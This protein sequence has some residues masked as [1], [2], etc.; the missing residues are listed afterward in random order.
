LK[1]LNLPTKVVAIT[2]AS[3]GLGAGLARVA[4]GAGA[5]VAVC[6]RAPAELRDGD[7]VLTA[8]L[9]VTDH[10]AVDGFA[11]SAFERFG[12]V[13]LWINNA[14]VIEPIGPLRSLEPDAVA[15]MLDVNIRGVANGCR[16]YLR[17]LHERRSRGMLVNISSGAARKAFFGWSIYCATKAAVDRM[18]EGIALE[19]EDTLDA[20]WSVAP[21]VIDTDMQAAI[22]SKIEAEF[23]DVERF[24]QMLDVGTLKSPDQTAARILQ[25]ALDPATPR[26]PVCVDL[27]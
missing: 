9:D 8:S 6:S 11:A 7:R 4:L 15:R 24:R 17:Q 23:R 21:G 3:R 2:G 26:N 5:S 14:G 10:R 22:R 1:E 25:F 13:D 19:E 27:R 16:A 20:V 12:R 18:S